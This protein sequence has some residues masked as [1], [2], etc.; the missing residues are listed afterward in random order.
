M[1]KRY[2]NPICDLFFMDDELLNV[3]SRFGTGNNNNE[4]YNPDGLDGNV[5]NEGVE[6][7]EDGI[8]AKGT[9]AIFDF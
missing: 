3:N 2:E 1:K 5:N 7:P 9:S 8:G 4:N 6:V